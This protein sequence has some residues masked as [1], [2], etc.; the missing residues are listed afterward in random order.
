MREIQ[1]YDPLLL[2]HTHTQIDLLVLQPQ[3]GSCTTIDTDGLD[4]EHIKVN[5]HNK[6]IDVVVHIVSRQSQFTKHGFNP[7]FFLRMDLI[8]HSS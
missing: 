3:R 1:W 2:Y 7:T 4:V 5:K 8:P 6:V